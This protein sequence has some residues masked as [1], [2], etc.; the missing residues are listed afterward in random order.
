MGNNIGVVEFASRLA[1]KTG[2]SKK[3]CEDFIRELFKI[4]T[5]VLT[6][7]ENLRIKGL[8]NFKVSVID[9]RSI[10]SV[11]TGEQRNIAKHK[12]VLFTPAKEMAS[13]I[14]APFEIFE[15]IELEDDFMASS[16]DSTYDDT[17]NATFVAGDENLIE[18]PILETGSDEE[19][20]DDEITTEA[21]TSI[22]TQEKS[23]KNLNANVEAAASEQK[24]DREKLLPVHYVEQSDDRGRYGKGFLTGAVSMFALCLLIFML[25][26]FFD[27]WPVNF[28]SSKSFIGAESVKNEKIVPEALEVSDTIKEEIEEPMVYDTVS[29]TR[30]LTTIAREHYGNHNFWPYIYEENKDILGH[31]DR[32]TPGTRVVV[33]PL[34]KYGVEVNNKKDIEEAKKMGRDI[35]LKFR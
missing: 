14:N 6:T 15:T 17:E 8:G 20:E 30:Y 34:S 9:S 35:Y 12:K 33:P 13:T 11:A 21:Y 31:P 10:I 29:T 4:A 3:L 24:I 25:G 16:N 23:K 27:W 22:E 2:K 19:N 28:G 18:K 32:I 26:C 7:G 1:K 5:E